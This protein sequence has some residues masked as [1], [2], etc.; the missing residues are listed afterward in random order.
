MPP[1]TIYRALACVAAMILVHV[2]AAGLPSKAGTIRVSYTSTYYAPKFASN[3]SA[4]VSGSGVAAFAA[5]ECTQLTWNTGLA[6][7]PGGRT[8]ARI[9]T[10]YYG[11]GTMS[12]NRNI[13]GNAPFVAYFRP[14]CTG[15]SVWW[16]GFYVSSD[17]TGEAMS[18]AVAY[19]AGLETYFCTQCR[20]AKCVLTFIADAV[21]EFTFCGWRLP[22]L[23][24]AFAC[25]CLRL[26]YELELDGELS[27]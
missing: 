21:E 10:T 7:E 14:R 8:R 22:C 13:N 9:P 24:P 11:G 19:R 5:G 2:A 17:C 26:L 18:A 20:K 3:G 16:D 12:D 23:A 25:V 4:T 15:D 27:D 6:F 1:A